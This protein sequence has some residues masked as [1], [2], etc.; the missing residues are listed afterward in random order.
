RNRCTRRAP[1]ARRR[2]PRIRV[3]PRCRAATSGTVRTATGWRAAWETSRARRCAHPTT[4][5]PMPSRRRQGSRRSPAVRPPTCAARAPTAQSR[6]PAPGRPRAQRATGRRGWWSPTSTTAA[7]PRPRPRAN[8]SARNSVTDRGRPAFSWVRRLPSAALDRLRQPGQA[9]LRAH[10][11][12]CQQ[13][14][15]LALVHVEARAVRLRVPQVQHG[16]AAAAVLAP[17]A[18]TD[19]AYKD[20]G[21]LAPPSGESGIEPVDRVEV[22]APERHVAA[23]R[24][25]PAALTAAGRHAGSREQQRGEPVDAAA[26]ALTA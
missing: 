2:T 17:N 8:R 21:I 23:A 4:P 18:M 3:A 11:W 19:H 26:H 10:A 5:A 16:G 14:I 13:L 22:A 24:A 15:E 25:A 1:A 20:I 9:L 7:T 6:S 12:F